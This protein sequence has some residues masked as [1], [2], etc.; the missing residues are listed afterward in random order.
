MFAINDSTNQMVAHFTTPTYGA[1]FEDA[2]NTV[3]GMYTYAEGGE[4]RYA[5]LLFSDGV[6]R[7]VFSFTG[8]GGTGALREIIPQPD[9]T[10]TVLQRW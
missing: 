2:V 10:F 3:D 7:Q 8:E 6:S 1:S 9:G 5:R 4:S